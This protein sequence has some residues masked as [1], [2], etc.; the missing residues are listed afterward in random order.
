MKLITKE[1]AQ[2][3]PGLYETEEQ[4]NDEKIAW[5]KLFTPDS[6]WT[7]YVVEYSASDGLCFGLVDGLEKELGYFS[8]PELE[9]VRGPLGLSVERDKFFVPMPL[10]DL[11]AN[12]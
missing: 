12:D 5:V 1:L 2:N 4:N 8:I 9:Q 3:I 11:I 10:S 7:W 6:S